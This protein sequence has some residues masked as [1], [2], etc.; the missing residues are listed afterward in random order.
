MPI[1]NPMLSAGHLGLVDILTYGSSRTDT[2]I[3]AVLADLGASPHVLLIPMVGDGVWTLNAAH[4]FPANLLVLLAAGV[5]IQ[6]TGNLTF[7]QTPLLFGGP[8]WYQGS[9]TV[10]VPAPPSVTVPGRIFGTTSAPLVAVGGSS[11]LVASGLLPL[12]TRV[13]IV[14]YHC[15]VS[16]GMS[17][18]LTSVDIG[19]ADLQDRWGHAIGITAGVMTGYGQALPG[20][21]VMPSAGDVWVTANGGPFDTV[22]T[23]VVTALWE[24]VNVS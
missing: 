11:R 8:G 22:G 6:G 12:G 15:T 2:T 21:V 3:D 10:T 14:A 17:G 18:G 4:V 23:C 19:H 1:T 13:S 20:E 9:G 7:G 24:Q 5:T 16:F